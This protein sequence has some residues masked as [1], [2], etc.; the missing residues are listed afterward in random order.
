MER[1]NKWIILLFLSKSSLKK[2]FTE[3]GNIPGEYLCDF[4]R[5][6]LE[7]WEWE[8]VNTSVGVEEGEDGENGN[9]DFPL[10]TPPAVSACILTLLNQNEVLLYGGQNERVY[11]T[12]LKFNFE[13]NEFKQISPHLDIQLQRVP[14]W[15]FGVAVTY[16]SRVYVFGGWTG[17]WFGQT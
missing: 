4:W 14:F 9:N 15:S 2:R 12:L 17:S 6:N 5:I 16:R 13:K 7:N 11:N 1:L 3:T 10:Q 8:K